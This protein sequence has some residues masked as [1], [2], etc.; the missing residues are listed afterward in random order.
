MKQWSELP[1]KKTA[2]GRMAGRREYGEAVK[3]IPR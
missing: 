3:L 1:G 2:P